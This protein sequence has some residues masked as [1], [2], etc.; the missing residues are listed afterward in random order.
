MSKLEAAGEEVTDEM[1]A[2][3]E[4]TAERELSYKEP[5]EV[6]EAFMHALFSDEP[7]L[8]YMV[9]PN[10]REGEMTIRTKIERARTQLNAVEPSPVQPGRACPDAR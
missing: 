2:D 9:V 10:R 5:D 7:L 6:T 8:R 4:K 3:Y 1:K